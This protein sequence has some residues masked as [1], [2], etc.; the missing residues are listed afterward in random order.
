[1]EDDL[2]NLV[3]PALRDEHGL[4]ILKFL[5]GGGFGAA[6]LAEAAVGFERMRLLFSRGA[7][8]PCPARA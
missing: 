4:H 7:A 6:Y 8:P 5:G 2:Y 1:M 3:L